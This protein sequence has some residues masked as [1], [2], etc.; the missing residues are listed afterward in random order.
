MAL[1][2][3]YFQPYLTISNAN[4]LRY[5]NA[6]NGKPHS[7]W[8]I[9]FFCIKVKSDHFHINFSLI[10]VEM[11]EVTRPLALVYCLVDF[12]SAVEAAKEYSKK[13]DKLT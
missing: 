7:N 8:R 12:T 2:N 9:N 10:K 6:T 13:L 5:N 4:S 1:I 3:T 11:R